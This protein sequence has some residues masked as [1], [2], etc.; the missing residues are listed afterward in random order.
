[1]KI[2]LVSCPMWDIEFPPYN[3]ALLSAVLRKY[4]FDVDCFDFNRDLFSSAV[5]QRHLWSLPDLYS[6]WQS[7]QNVDDFFINES[8]AI[9]DFVLSLRNYDII[10]FTLQ[11]LNFVFSIK[12]ARHLKKIYQDK[13]IL[14][15]G[16]ECFQNF[17]PE[18]LTRCGC[19]DA[20]C[21]QE[22]ELCLPEL[23]TK[24][25]NNK[26][27][28]TAG[29]FIKRGNNYLN[30]GTREL[31]PDLDELPFAD[32][33]FL[34]ECTEKISISTS[35]GCTNNC[36]FC[37]EKS[38]WDKFR[39]RSAESVVKELRLS[40]K[41]F[42]LL[43]FAYLNDSLINGNT[44]EFDKFCDLMISERLNVNWGG[45]I[46]VRKEMDKRFFTKMKKAGAERLNFGIESGSDR[47][48]S[49]MRKSFKKELALKTLKNARAA[50]VYF[51]VNLVV[52]FP[53][54]TEAD[55]KETEV[56][57]REIRK[58]TDCVH[59]N[60]CYVLKGSNLYT[61]PDRWGISL[62][63]NFVTDWCSKDGSNDPSIRRGRIAALLERR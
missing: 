59:V 56:L 28:N 8:S 20:V 54:E 36:S 14:G 53:G 38:H 11:S 52:G 60:P 30:C 25:K 6:F 33:R 42:P 26:D 16:P 2:A 57:Y 21:S 49:L 12:L 40:K 41:H 29:F 63:E 62:T 9:D 19:F 22:A 45:H 43:K 27:L 13:I 23:L 44:M 5:S 7:Q 3:I 31:V 61:D 37:H 32:Y 39:Y 1:M 58:L 17:N 34:N 15:G 10:G 18:H 4:N 47:I 50:G 51:S 55:F 24:I 35:R 46:L 48:L